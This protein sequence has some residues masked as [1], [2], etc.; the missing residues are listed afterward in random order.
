[1]P[2]AS[3]T[4]APSATLPETSAPAA[5]AATA[6]AGGVLSVVIV[7]TG[8]TPEF[9][10]ASYAL[11]EMP[12]GPSATAVLSQLAV[13]G[14]ADAVAIRTPSTRNS[15][16]ETATSSDADAAIATDPRCSDPDAGA[17]SE[18]VGGVWSSTVTVISEETPAF[19]A[20]SSARACSVWTPAFAFHVNRAGE[21]AAVPARAPSTRRSTSTTPTS[22][23]ALAVTVTSPG[24]RVSPSAG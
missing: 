7:T 4:V 12:C 10:A 19:L 24:T 11:V 21:E 16:R 17:V 5:G 15:T 20:A 3:E 18:T 2:L 14:A 6:T 8:E 1:M 22:S 13:Q 23:E 9:P